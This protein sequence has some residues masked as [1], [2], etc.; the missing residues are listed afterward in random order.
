MTTHYARYDAGTLYYKA[1][2]WPSSID[3]DG[4]ATDLDNLFSILDGVGD[5]VVLAAKTYSGTEIDATDGIDILGGSIIVRSAFSTDPDYETYG[6][7]IILDGVGKTDII[8]HI[9]SANVTM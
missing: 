6:G 5:T 2:E 3:N 8:F 9:K 7:N 4:S 1:S